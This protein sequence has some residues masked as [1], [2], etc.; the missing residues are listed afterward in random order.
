MSDPHQLSGNSPI[1]ATPRSRTARTDR[2]QPTVHSP[3]PTAHGFSLIEIIIAIAIAGMAFVVLTQT[4]VYTLDALHGVR[5]EPHERPDLRFV[6]SQIILEQDRDS[7]ENGG[8]IETLDIGTVR[9]EGIIE[10]TA[11]V[12]LFRVELQLD[13]DLPDGERRDQRETLYLLRPTWSDPAERSI[14]LDDAR[15]ELETE[16]AFGN[17]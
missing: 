3:P 13:I 17:W 10:E 16:R 5:N 6:R 14:L 4:F 15:R 7:F 11:V 1:A 2:P 9:W 12:D 8:E